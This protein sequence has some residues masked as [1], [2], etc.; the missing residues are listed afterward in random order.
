MKKLS[1]FNIFTLAF[2]AIFFFAPLVGA[3]EYAFRGVNGVGHSLI[4]FQWIFQQDGFYTNLGMS[5]RLAAVTALLVMVLMVPTVVFL[6]LGGKKWR[7]IIEFVCLVPVVVPVVSL[8]IGAQISMPKWLQSTPYELCFF[9]VIVSMPYVY[10]AIDIGLQ[11][12]SL[13][14]LVEASQSLGASGLTTLRLVIVPAIRSAVTGALFISI[15]L[16]LGEYALASLLHFNTF[17]TW[18]TNVSQENILGSIALSV[19]TLIGAWVV[20]II[21]AF[22]PKIRRKRKVVA[23]VN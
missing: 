20:L 3:L 15:A 23:H 4:N 16:S 5:L 9:Y 19:S 17:P 18:V 11:S 6:H 14:T 12:V 22:L 7:R 10:R 1:K 8:A 21:I 13:S 2:A